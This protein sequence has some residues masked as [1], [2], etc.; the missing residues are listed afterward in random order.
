MLKTEL[1]EEVSSKINKKRLLHTLSVEKEALKL[2]GHY[3][4]SLEEA[5]AAAIL[6]DIC[7]DFSIEEMN[8]YVK[9]Y[10]L[11]NIYLNNIALSHAK[12]AA[13]YVKEKLKIEN[14]DVI[15]AINFHTTGR[16]NMS[17]LGKIIYIADI[18]EEN[19]DFEGV[20]TLRELAYLHLDKAV[21]YAL[22]LSIKYVID[23]NEYLH[24]DTVLARNSLLTESRR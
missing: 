6:H 4:C 20:E 12:V 15:D 24:M 17:M 13:N 9:K 23:K 1:I 7:R 22:D 16:E 3:G 5:S 18:I 19:R 11:D 14:Q 10:N 21:L 8:E 2:A